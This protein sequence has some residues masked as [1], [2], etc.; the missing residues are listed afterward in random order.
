VRSDNAGGVV[1][2]VEPVKLG[3][4]QETWEFAVALNTHSVDL[5][6]DL[7]QVAVLRCERGEEHLPLAWE[8]SPPGGHHRQGLL[9]FSP[10]DHSSSFI[11]IVIRGVANVPERVFRWEA[12]PTVSVPVAAATQTQSA[13]IPRLVIS[14]SEFSFGDLPVTGKPVQQVAT[15]SNQGTGSLLI[16]KV[17]TT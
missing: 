3:D 4:D 8:G 7:T 1:I 14:P 13:G 12:K 17:V 11:E 10:L 15:L 5:A 2:D 6:Y 16:S 9:R